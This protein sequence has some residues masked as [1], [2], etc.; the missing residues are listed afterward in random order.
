[1]SKYIYVCRL[2]FQSFQLFFQITMSDCT[3]CP[4]GSHSP[5]LFLCDL[6]SHLNK[7]KDGYKSVYDGFSYVLK[8][9]DGE[10][11]L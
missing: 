3:Q 7:D 2:K 9:A 4:A 8:N 6:N 10:K 5:L 11:V 1:M